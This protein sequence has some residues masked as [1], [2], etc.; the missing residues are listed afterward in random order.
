M[1]AIRPEGPNKAKDRNGNQCT[2][3]PRPEHTEQSGHATKRRRPD[4]RLTRYVKT[5]EELQKKSNKKKSQRRK[6]RKAWTDRR[7]QRSGNRKQEERG[8]RGR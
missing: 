6:K 4:R 8:G 7:E 3:K 1:M 5:K 2:A